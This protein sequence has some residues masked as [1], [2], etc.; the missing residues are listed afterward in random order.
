VQRAGVYIPLL[1]AV[2]TT[3]RNSADYTI[4]GDAGK[5]TEDPA[6]RSTR[7]FCVH[8][9]DKLKKARP[10]DPKILCACNSVENGDG[11]K[12]LLLLN[13]AHTSSSNQAVALLRA[14][15]EQHRSTDEARRTNRG[16]TKENARFRAKSTGRKKVT[17]RYFP[18]CCAAGPG[19]P[20]F[21]LLSSN[22]RG[23]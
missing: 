6:D 14:R 4:E 23:L 20:C 11:I 17:S 21:L 9:E 13:L 10:S 1:S 12:K 5:T 19:T 15:E 2:S 16:R 7:Q 3:P 22:V 8:P 18:A